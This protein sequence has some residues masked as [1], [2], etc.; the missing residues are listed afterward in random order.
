MRKNIVLVGPNLPMTCRIIEVNGVVAH[1]AVAIEALG[2]RW[3]WHQRVRAGK[4]AD[5]GQVV[6]H[7]HV[8]E[9]QVRGPGVV[10]AVAG[11]AAVGEGGVGGVVGLSA[12]GAEALS[13]RSLPATSW[14]R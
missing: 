4:A 14:G 13:C 7:V 8:D 12:V 9:A 10:H 5:F 3:I 11:E 1:I 2:V 6:A